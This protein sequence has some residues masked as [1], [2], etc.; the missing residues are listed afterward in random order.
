LTLDVLHQ[1]TVSHL[2]PGSTG[3]RADT[4]L[5]P[6]DRVAVDLREVVTDAAHDLDAAAARRSVA[7]QI[8]APED[9]VSVTASEES[10]RRLFV[11]LIDNAVRYTPPG[12]VVRVAV[13]RVNG[14]G[15]AVDVTDSG[16]GIEPG[17][18]PRVFDRFYR[19]EA[20]RAEAADGLGLGLSIARTIVQHH[21]GGLISCRMDAKGCRDGDDISAMGDQRSRRLW[22]SI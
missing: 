12:G 9:S 8:D 2:I 11:I 7:L 19:G 4:G 20:A 6:H 5:E 13:T 16:M 14:S 1:A 22:E 10:L 3:S 21:Q 18:R 15:A 17:D